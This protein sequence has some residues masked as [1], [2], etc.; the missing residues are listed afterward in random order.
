MLDDTGLSEIERGVDRPP[1]QCALMRPAPG[2]E[3][4]PDAA[5]LIAHILERYH[6]THRREFPE[7]I[8]LAR[9]AKAEA[10]TA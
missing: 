3:P 8:E 1:L 6:E 10:I 4:R 2:T 9:A 5:P 7:A